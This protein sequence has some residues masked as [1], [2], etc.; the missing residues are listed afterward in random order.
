[1]RQIYNQMPYESFLSLRTVIPKSS[2]QAAILVPNA[3]IAYNFLKGFMRVTFRVCC[4]LV[5]VSSEVPDL[6][7][8]KIRYFVFLKLGFF[9]KVSKQLLA[10]CWNKTIASY[11]RT[12]L[13]NAMHDPGLDPALRV[14]GRGI[15]IAQK[16]ITRKMDEIWIWTV[17]YMVVLQW[18]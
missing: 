3:S 12:S 17:K 5:L 10:K 15:G 1:M 2:H 9:K 18:C 6:H 16:D 4:I 11:Q 7:P 13:L 14:E 8:G